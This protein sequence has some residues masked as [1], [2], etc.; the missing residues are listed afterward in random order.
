MSKFKLKALLIPKEYEKI[1]IENIDPREYLKFLYL[2]DPNS[3]I[4]ELEEGLCKRFKRR[5]PKEDDL[6]VF[7]Y[8]DHEL[9]DL[10]P[11]FEI[12]DI[13]DE[14]NNEIRILVDNTFKNVIYSPEPN[15]STHIDFQKTRTI[16]GGV[17]SKES[18]Q[19]DMTPRR[20]TSSTI[21]SPV[22]L[23]PP[24]S[25]TKSGRSV[26][27]KKPVQKTKS[28]RI[29]SGMLESSPISKEKQLSNTSRSSTTTVRS[30]SKSGSRDKSKKRSYREISSDEGNGSSSEDNFDME[31]DVDYEPDDIA[32]IDDDENEKIEPEEMI[33]MVADLKNKDDIVVDDE[34]LNLSERQRAI[35][36][37][38]QINTVEGNPSLY[39]GRTKRRA[40]REAS[41]VLSGSKSNKTTSRTS[42]VK[43]PAVQSS[44]KKSGS[45][46]SHTKSNHSLVPSSAK[47]STSTSS[48]MKHSSVASPATPGSSKSK[49]KISSTTSASNKAIKPKVKIVVKP[50]SVKKVSILSD[51]HERLKKYEKRIMDLM[52][53][54]EDGGIDG[55][56]AIP[57]D[58]DE[59]LRPSE[60]LY[61][62]TPVDVKL[63]LTNRDGS[64]RNSVVSLPDD[65]SPVESEN[66]SELKHE[67]PESNGLFSSQDSSSPTQGSFTDSKTATEKPIVNTSV[68]ENDVSTDQKII[69]AAIDIAKA[70][71][72][73]NNAATNQTDMTRNVDIPK[74]SIDTI[75][76]MDGTNAKPGANTPKPIATTNDDT[77]MEIATDT[78]VTDNVNTN[79][80]ET[81]IENKNANGNGSAGL[82]ENIKVNGN[83]VN[84]GTQ[85]FNET[86][87]NQA[88]NETNINSEIND[89][90]YNNDDKNQDNTVDS[91][92]VDNNFDNSINSDNES[93]HKHKS[94][95]NA[96]AKINDS[97]DD[98]DDGQIN[99]NSAIEVPIIDKVEDVFAKIEDSSDEEKERSKKFDIFAKIV[100]SSDEEAG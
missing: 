66:K 10:D 5:Y 68:V 75:T 33:G 64:D 20:T 87:G 80:N 46:K 9:L 7:S 98:E 92:I 96:F 43:K 97:S 39:L 95:T 67:A 42:K 13:F 22:T 83:N 76:V 54:N 30:P 52:V 2:V 53:K 93:V 21:S 78:V 15:I 55:Y 90:N 88:F 70:S 18:N 26:P 34:F 23:A 100:D 81:I 91:M 35:Y 74:P 99:M 50:P 59:G 82:E 8:Q 38:L 89:I 47:P 60:G 12:S 4:D 6:I 72:L 14:Q 57:V 16:P 79:G 49:S 77:P 11:E 31:E 37:E 48:T 28:S 17:Y 24:P 94:S 69:T 3:T 73:A 62:E 61:N 65:N 51:I 71:V 58:F 44:V 84:N 36:K 63:Y 19:V 45:T 41:M 25:R 29:T 1:S 56:D 40:A 27:E 32:P 86:N 85:A